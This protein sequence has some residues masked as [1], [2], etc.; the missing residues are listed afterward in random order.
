MLVWLVPRLGDRGRSARP[1]QVVFALGLGF[2]MNNVKRFSALGA[3]LLLVIGFAFIV[4]RRFLS[5]WPSA[6]SRIALGMTQQEVEATIGFPPGYYEGQRP[7]PLSMSRI[8]KTPP[9]R[10]A[11]LDF[12]DS[13]F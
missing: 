5:P 2:V 11:G 1:L 13:R 12:E 8:L 6:Y 7:M 4:G 3:L 10:Q 9:L